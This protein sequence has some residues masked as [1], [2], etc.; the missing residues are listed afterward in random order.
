MLAYLIRSKPRAGKFNRSDPGSSPSLLPFSWHLLD[1]CEAE[2]MGIIF[3]HLLLCV[4]L[5]TIL[6]G[7]QELNRSGV[8]ANIIN[9]NIYQM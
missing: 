6:L 4:R 7:E 2:K 5:A 3:R 1:D 8:G 9:I